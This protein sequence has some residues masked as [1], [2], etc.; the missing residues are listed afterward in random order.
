M[1]KALKYI[2]LVVGFII[3]VTG[4]SINPSNHVVIGSAWVYIDTLKLLL[5]PAIVLLGVFIWLDARS[6]NKD[7]MATSYLTIDTK[8]TKSNAEFGSTDTTSHRKMWRYLLMAA[9][10]IIAWFVVP[11]YCTVSQLKYENISINDQG[12]LGKN[13]ECK[14]YLTINIPYGTASVAYEFA[15]YSEGEGTPSLQLLGGL[16]QLV[17]GFYHLQGTNMIG[18]ALERMSYPSTE[19]ACNIYIFKDKNYLS[20]FLNADVNKFPSYKCIDYMK[21]RNSGIHEIPNIESGATYYIC[22]ENPSSDRVQVVFEACAIERSILFKLLLIGG[23]V[24]AVIFFTRDKKKLLKIQNINNKKNTTPPPYTKSNAA[25]TE[26]MARIKEMQTAIKVKMAELDTASS[27][28][29]S[30]I[31][32][33]RAIENRTIADLYGAS[34]PVEYNDLYR[35][36]DWIKSQFGNKV[37]PTPMLQCDRTISNA[38]NAVKQKL[39]LLNR[40]N[41]LLNKYKKMDV[42]LSKQYN[43]QQ[44]IENQKA[45]SSQLNAAT[46]NQ[47][48]RIA[49]SVYSGET[50]KNISQEFETLNAEIQILRE[51]QIRIGTIEI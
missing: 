22:F 13:S 42:E 47:E 15:T 21:L 33:I 24:F 30:D 10:V 12:W 3:C 25:I 23:I 48:E 32:K 45:F 11:D 20:E 44:Q 50:L 7:T 40:N 34:L 2:L 17:G 35:N 43:I 41:E 4:V 37:D 28:I 16:V 1:K 49:A 31:Q 9:G 26:E 27:N 5:I 36:Y 8:Q 18:N 51:E 14:N 29:N 46:A 6:S 38:E 39:T 19:H